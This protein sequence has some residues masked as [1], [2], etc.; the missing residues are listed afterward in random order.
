MNDFLTTHSAMANFVIVLVACAAFPAASSLAA[1][2]QLQDSAL[3][4]T[5]PHRYRAT[6]RDIFSLLPLLTST[7]AAADDSRS[8]VTL[9][10]NS[11]DQKAG[12]KLGEV[13]IGSPP[14]TAVAVERVLPGGVAE[15]AGVQAGVVLLDFSNAKSVADRLHNGPYPID[16][17]FYNLAAGGDAFGDL[18]KP[19][20]TAQDALELAK[21]TTTTTPESGEKFVIRVLKQP[22]ASCGIQSRRGDVLEINYEARI[23][24]ANGPIYDSS[25]QRGTGLPYQFVLGSGDMIPGVDRGMYDMCPGEARLLEIPPVLGYGPRASKLF[26]IPNGSRLFWTVE[27]VTVNSA[28]K[29]DERTR[30]ELEGRAW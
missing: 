1:N 2:R 14:R 20:V 7:S 26:D 28:Q 27:L 30:D 5:G 11:P 25:G 8:T 24:T 4:L 18:G 12:L 23:M 13:T 21:S 15:R 3:S 19:L 10:L 17:N 29:G 9:R 6:R 16:L 22:P